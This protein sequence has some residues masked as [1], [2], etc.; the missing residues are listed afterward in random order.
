MKDPIVK[1]KL[2]SGEPKISGVRVDDGSIV[3]TF[4]MTGIG[5]NL[6]EIIAT[7]DDLTVELKDGNQYVNKFKVMFISDELD[8]RNFTYTKV[9]GIV[10]ITIPIFEE[11][12][13]NIEPI[14]ILI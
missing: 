7:V 10:K 3:L 2:I 11:D 13:I 14:I 4:V 8:F 1:V 9:D 5:R 6:T 12:E